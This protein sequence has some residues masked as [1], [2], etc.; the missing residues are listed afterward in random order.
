MKGRTFFS[1]PIFRRDEEKTLEAI[2][3]NA[4]LW[5]V[6]TLIV[7]IQIG[8]YL[9]G[10]I[11]VIVTLSNYIF[12]ALCFLMRY[13]LQRGRL[14]WAS[15]GLLIFGVIHL[16]VTLAILGTIRTPLST[17]YILVVVFSG[18]QFGDKGILGST[19]MIAVIFLALITAQNQH[20]LNTPDYSV[21]ITQ[22][23]SY[24]AIFG[25]TGNFM[26]IAIK[27]VRRSLR[28]SRREILR[29]RNAEGRLR[30]F[31]RAI[32]HNPAS[33]MITNK[34]GV[35]EEVNPKF[36]QLSGFSKEEAIGANPNIQKSGFHSKAFYENLWGTILSG[37]E[38]QGMLKNK[39]K[40]GEL[41]WEKASI[42]PV[43]NEEN[44]IT[45]FIAIKEDITEQ[46]KAQKIQSATNKQLKEQIRKINILQETLKKQALHDSLTG[47]HNRRYLD[48]MLEKEFA[49]AK[50][51]GHPISII[52]LDMDYLKEFND[53]G[54]HITGDH[55]LRTLASQLRLFI[56]Q[57]DTVCRYGGDE[58]AVILPKTSGKDALT[59]AEELRK[60]IMELTL[61][62]RAET[63]LRITFTAGIA[64]YPTHGETIEEIFNFADVALYR[65]KLKGRNRVELFDLSQ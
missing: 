36:L 31:S 38:W 8:N 42:S 5:T 33:I 59:R 25:L 23:I 52:L 45:H 39:K 40:N 58:F 30:I 60:R 32:K 54:G 15:F 21:G 56:R 22:W 27:I 3:L 55:A 46:R 10:G 64:T 24:V 44:T 51:G 20:L 53:L 6:I 11:P 4:A 16:T 35:I 7:V 1:P 13:V 47:L 63:T 19:A 17:A 65:A 50:R 28:R 34:N 18:F 61:L 37:K 49:R 14:K 48:E 41:Y 26:Y 9:G 57:E 29:R 43:F 62:Y 12:L 2:T